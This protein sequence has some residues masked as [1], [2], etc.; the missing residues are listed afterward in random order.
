MD[1]KYQD[2]LDRKF[3]QMGVDMNRADVHLLDEFD[4]LSPYVATSLISEWLREKRMNVLF[5]VLDRANYDLRTL[6]IPKFVDY[7]VYASMSRP[8]SPTWL[9]PKYAD[10]PLYTVEYGA[11]YLIVPTDYQTDRKYTRLPSGRAVHNW[12]VSRELLDKGFCEHHDLV[13]L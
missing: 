9:R 13:L 2:F 3:Q 8:L 1:K 4:E 10:R 5:L 7:C 6:G 12:L 11:D